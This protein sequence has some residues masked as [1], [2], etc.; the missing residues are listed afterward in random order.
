L[1]GELLVGLRERG[2]ELTRPILWV[3][4]GAK[5]LGRAVLDVLDHPVLARCQQHKISNVRDRLPG[6]LGG[7][8][9]RRLRVAY[10]A[11]S[12]LDA[13]AQLEALAGEL[14]KTHPGAA[15]SLREGL[16]EP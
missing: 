7:P 9:E 12:A 13:Q 6:R 5:A 16:A 8:V 11:A 3:P 10:H 2:L 14:D 15:T 4:D 1:A